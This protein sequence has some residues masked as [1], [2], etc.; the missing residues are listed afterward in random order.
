MAPVA[1]GWKD[2]DAYKSADGHGDVDK[3]KALLA[4]A[5]PKLTYCYA[6]TAT[7]QKYAVVIQNSLQRAGFQITLNSIDRNSYYTTVGDKTTTC[8]LIFSGWGQDYPDPE[9]TLDVLLNGEGIVPKGNQNF[10][11]FNEPSINKKLDDLKIEPDRSKAADAYAA[12][13]QEIMTDFAPLIPMYYSKAF[14]MRGSKVWSFISPLFSNYNLV[15]AYV[16]G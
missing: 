13:D 1:P 4:G 10:S 16:T 14:N 15:D 5:T 7:Q 9:A 3:A 11:Y 8:D 12:L 2:Y 6:N